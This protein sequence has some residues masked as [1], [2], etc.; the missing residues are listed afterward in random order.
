MQECYQ[1][2]SYNGGD[3]KASVKGKTTTIGR[4]LKSPGVIDLDSLIEQE[5]VK[6]IVCY[7]K[8]LRT[9]NRNLEEK[10]EPAEL[11][12]DYFDRLIDL[13]NEEIDFE[14]NKRI[15]LFPRLE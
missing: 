3:N 1:E 5:N 14:I 2:P 11:S 8:D 6:D 7:L 13:K 15:D 9:R 12:E 4:V 10:G